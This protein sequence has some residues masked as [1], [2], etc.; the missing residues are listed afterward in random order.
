VSAELLGGERVTIVFDDHTVQTFER[1]MSE[2]LQRHVADEDTEVI[3]LWRFVTPMS[4]RQKR[5]LPPLAEV[6]LSAPLRDQIKQGMERIEQMERREQITDRTRGKK[7][8]QR[9]ADDMVAETYE[10]G[11]GIPRINVALLW[12]IFDGLARSGTPEI[13]TRQLQEFIARGANR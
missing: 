3:D 9:I 1:T 8:T 12:H 4:A 11:H 7:S 5:R 2:A 6:D 13:D 10:L